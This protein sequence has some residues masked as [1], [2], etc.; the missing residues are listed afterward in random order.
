MR[1]SFLQS[2]K[3]S[4]MTSQNNLEIKGD[5]SVSPLAELFVEIGQAQLD[6]SM[7]FSS[8]DRKIIAYF[9]HGKLVYAIS[10]SRTSRLFDILLRENKI[11]K[12]TLLAIPNFTNDM[13]LAKFLLENNLFSKDEI[14]AL[15]SYQIEE[16]LRECLTWTKG[17]WSFNPLARIREGI[18]FKINLPKLLVEHARSLSSESSSKRFRSFQESFVG[19]NLSEITINLKPQEAYILSRFSGEEMNIEQIKILGGLPDDEI[20]RTLYTLWLGGFLTRKN[21]NSAFT[22]N[23]IAGIKSATISLKQKAS[24]MSQPIIEVPK[25]VV[26][27]TPVETKPEEAETIAEVEVTLEEYLEKNE[28]ATNHYEVL[29]VELKASTEEI[30]KSYFKLAKRFHPDIFHRSVKPEIHRKIQNA[31]TKLAGAHETLRDKDLREI[32]DY[33]LRKELTEMEARRASG[34]PVEKTDLVDKE[35]VAAEQFE[36]GYDLLM[37][38]YYAEAAPFLARAVHLAPNNARYHAFFG[39]VLAQEAKYRHKAEGEIQTAIKLEPNNELYR[40]ISAEFFIQYNLLKRAEGE[41]KRLLA[42]A[43]NNTEAQNLLDS[44]QNK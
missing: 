27:E 6:G 13:E 3:S 36:Q 12:K 34:K 17:E 42:I 40:I 1:D 35:A 4:K 37:D 10:N 23:R 20:F 28:D 44:L 33:K 29:G 7:R 14:D 31:F 26:E 39:K 22:E 16:I 24:V 38:E 15:F 8:E 18:C 9:Q 32:Y 11:D 43:P 21:W 19:K 25:A 5:F 30:K 41:L 2:A